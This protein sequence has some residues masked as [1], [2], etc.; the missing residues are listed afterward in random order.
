MCTHASPMQ[1]IFMY[2]ITSNCYSLVQVIV[3]KNKTISRS[4]GIP[5]K[6]DLEA[7]Q[8]PV[9]PTVLYSQKPRQRPS[10]QP[11]KDEPLSQK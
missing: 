8:A 11:A 5:Q 3:L 1:G 9:V 6:A 4:L 10:A 2:W 7:K